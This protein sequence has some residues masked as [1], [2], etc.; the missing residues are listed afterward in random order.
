MSFIQLGSA[1][2][3]ASVLVK[4]TL[5]LLNDTFPLAPPYTKDELGNYV[6]LLGSISTA[7]AFAIGFGIVWGIVTLRESKR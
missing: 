4:P 2:M 5:A 3:I 1:V 7:I 6:F